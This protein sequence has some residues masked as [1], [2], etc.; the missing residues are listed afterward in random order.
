MSERSASSTGRH[1]VLADPSGRRR[2]RLVIAGRVATAALGL[3]LVTLT[4]GGLGLQPLA[5]L[6]VV[7]DL[8]TGPDA[9]PALPE[10]VRAAVGRGTTVVPLTT[11]AAPAQRA[12]SG[13]PSP[14][15]SATTTAPARTRTPSRKAAGKTTAT[16]TTTA[17]ATTS[18]T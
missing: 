4:L 8:G 13:V 17:P 16:P 15:R 18:P 6:P 9:P 1:Q 5:G 11:P 2:R 12:P 3:W 7:G 10:R 14:R